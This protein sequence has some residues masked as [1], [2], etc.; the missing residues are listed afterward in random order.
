MT[1]K[2]DRLNWYGTLTIENIEA[3]VNLLKRLLEGK[4]YTFVACNEGR[5]NF[6]PEVRTSQQLTGTFKTWEG[7]KK[8]FAGF[9]VSD[10]YGVWDLSTS[11]HDSDG[12]DPSFN[13]PYI[14]FERNKVTITHRAP[15]GTLLYWCV[16]VEETPESDGV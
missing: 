13:A 4:R 16:A 1:R 8:D 10:T 7:E 15:T 3:V 11:R 6:R 9:N 12:Y 14:V 2:I 5:R